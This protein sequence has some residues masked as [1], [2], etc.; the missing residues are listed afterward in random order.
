MK[1]VEIVVIK[2]PK[3]KDPVMIQ[4]L[5]G[6]GHVG[7][8]VADHLV[9]ELDSEKVLEVYSPH[10]PPQVI[11]EKDGMIRLVRN[12]MYACRAG[13][14]D[15]LVLVGDYQSATNVG[16]YILSDFYVETA[17]KFGVKR[18]YTIG[19]YATG[20]FEE[21]PKV[22]GAVNNPKLIEEMKKFGVEFGTREPA[23]GIVGAA[24]LVPALAKRRGIDAVCLLGV[25]SG[26]V[27]DPN[28]AQEVLRVLCRILGIEVDMS[29]LEER[30]KEM[31][32][33]LTKLE[34]A[35]RAIARARAED[36]GYIR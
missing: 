36:L 15:L 4:G 23:G 35:E 2:E 29:A 7:K 9:E 5:P 34:E 6:V 32:K 33:F 16:Y 10:F 14:V 26:Y 13:N 31:K 22:I 20:E 11:V 8:L 25:T 27:V 17:A 28:S 3:L 19:G 30:A 12:E 21:H 1:D 18:I 24:G